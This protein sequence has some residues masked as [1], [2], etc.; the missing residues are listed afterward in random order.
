MYMYMLMWWIIKVL[1]GAMMIIA[2]GS[3]TLLHPG[4]CFQGHWKGAREPWP[5]DQEL[6]ESLDH[7]DG[8][9]KNVTIET[10]E[11]QSAAV[12]IA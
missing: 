10:K 2:T 6:E 3:L 9:N 1:E 7:K 8:N 11:V 5:R 12:S 4:L